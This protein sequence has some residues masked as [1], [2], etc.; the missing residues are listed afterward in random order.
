M[1]MFIFEVENSVKEYYVVVAS[2]SESA[3][4]IMEKE[5]HERITLVR[6]VKIEKNVPIFIGQFDSVRVLKRCEVIYP[7]GFGQYRTYLPDQEVKEL[8]ERGFEV[9]VYD[10]GEIRQLSSGFTLVEEFSKSEPK[11]KES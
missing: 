3:F 11:V 8:L 4:E 7:G 9:N 5:S 10:N 2:D 6:G 1:K